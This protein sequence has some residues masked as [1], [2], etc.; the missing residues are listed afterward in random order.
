MKRCFLLLYSILFIFEGCA[1]RGDNISNTE[2]TNNSIIDSLEEVKVQKY[3]VPENYNVKII[4]YDT[5]ITDPADDQR[6][7]YRI[8]IDRIESGRTMIALESQEKFIEFSVPEGKHLLT[9][10]KYILDERKASISVLKIFFSR[11]PTADTLLQQ[12]IKF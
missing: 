7:Y 4:T 9:I 12:M 3:K 2:N 10:E 1:T 5:G 8:M 6:G 11:I